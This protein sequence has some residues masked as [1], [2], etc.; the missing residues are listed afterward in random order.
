[1]KLDISN[2]LRSQLDRRAQDQGFDSK[3]DYCIM[4]L[5]TVMDE[6]ESVENESIEDSNT[7]Q[8]VKGRLEDLGYID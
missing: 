7:D 4:V 1:M 2:S 6:V 3:E 5:E 8:T